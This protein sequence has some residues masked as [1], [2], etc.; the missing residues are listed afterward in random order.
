MVGAEKQQLFQS[1][2]LFVFPGIGQEGQ[3][4]VVLEAMASGLPVIFTHRGCLRE[5]VVNGEAGIE[6][7]CYDHFDLALKIC[8]L[9]DQPHEMIRLG[10][11]A[12]HRFQ[13]YFTQDRYTGRMVRVLEEAV[14]QLPSAPPTPPVQLVG[15]WERKGS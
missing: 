11:N 4:L 12:R 1:A 10:L 15:S 14:G 6:A 9:L 7:Y 5:T 8:H 3:P 13:T 2:D